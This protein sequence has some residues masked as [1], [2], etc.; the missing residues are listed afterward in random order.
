MAE[1]L[2]INGVSLATYAFMLPDISGVMRA[3][4]RRG[5]NVVVPNRH[6]RIK[7][8]GKRFDANEI[9]FSLWV[10]GA[11]PE[12]G[13]L[14]T[15]QE[16]LEEFFARRDQLL[17][18]LYSDP[19]VLEYTR[20]DGHRV[21][22]RGEVV[23]VLDFTR[24]RDEPMAQV[25]VAIELTDGFWED[26]ATVAQEITGTSGTAVEM[27]EFAGATAPMSDLVITVF[28]P[29]N[30]PMFSHGNYWVKYNGVINAGHQL[31]IDCGRWIV[32]PGTG[33]LWQ[34]TVANIEQGRPGPWF[35]LDPSV[36]PFEVTFT[37]TTG[38]S[39][40]ATISGRRKYLSP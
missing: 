14:P 33:T 11:D 2:T 5:E 18:L 23:D 35:E 10:V 22:A 21:Q 4:A 16:E 40:T 25:S 12:T 27:T 38:Q 37:H 39:V 3:P 36:D 7:T 30:N 15:K 17:K 1:D 19:L 31:Q 6:G 32:G 28:G 20:P 24:R 13:K 8:I 34:P 9:T 29:C 26:S